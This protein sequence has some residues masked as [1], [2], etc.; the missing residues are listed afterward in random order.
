MVETALSALA[1][2]DDWLSCAHFG[3]KF[4]G[5]GLDRQVFWGVN[6]GGGDCLFTGV[7]AELPGELVCGTGTETRPGIYCCIFVGALCI[8]G[9]RNY[10]VPVSLC[11]GPT[12]SHAVAGVV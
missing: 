10:A 5:N 7:F 12:T 11:S 2:I 9:V 8:N 6:W 1:V 4:L 3:L